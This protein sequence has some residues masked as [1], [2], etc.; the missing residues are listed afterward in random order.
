MAVPSL[1]LLFAIPIPDPLDN[2]IL[3]ALQRSAAAGALWLHTL[4]GLGTTG[5]AVM[6]QRESSGFLV[7]EE[8]SGLRGL[9]TLGLVSLVI[10]DLFAHAGPRVWWVVLL[11]PPVAWGINVVRVAWIAAGDASAEASGHLGQGVVTLLA[12]TVVLFF[13]GHFLSRGVP[14]PEQAPPVSGPWPWRAACAGLAL[15]VAAAAVVP[16]RPPPPPLRLSLEGGFADRDGWVGERLAADLLF[17]GHVAVGGVLQRRYERRTGGSEVELVE[18]FVG[19]ERANRA[20]ESPWSSK[21]ALPGRDWSL[22]EVSTEQD[23]RLFREVDVAIA[24]RGEQR[25]LVQ[26]W[27]LG[28]AGVLR[29]TL[30]SFFAAGPAFDRGGAGRK[31]RS[32]VRLVTPIRSAGSAGRDRARQVLGRFLVAFGGELEALE[33][34]GA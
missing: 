8:C 34:G 31:P 32:F 23:W 18:L 9:L 20:R 22:L 12:G 15:I 2:E 19:L 6:L 21:L 28:G 26:T 4:V 14:E 25:A 17:I 7:I 30:R 29:E 16:T 11:A 33:P 24:A 13:V 27:R 5:E 3:W 10:R 1:A